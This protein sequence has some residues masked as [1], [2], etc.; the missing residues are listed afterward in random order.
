M[1]KAPKLKVFRTPI[2]FHD[3]YVAAPSQKAAL[4]AWGS[5]HDL[6]ARGVAE[7]VEDPEL[8]REPLEHPGTVIRR[9]R[10]TTAE[11][12]A[13]LPED[14]PR[15]R[16]SPPEADAPARPARGPKAAPKPKPKPKPDRA[17][18]REAEEALAEAEARHADA[19]AELARREAALARER[20]ALEK[21]QSAEQARLAR[22]LDEAR[23]RYDRAIREWRG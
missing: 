13:A 21:Q 7:R 3:A 11:Q 22:H 9:L 5:D 12:I 20:R 1:A 6:F 15:A 4:E 19:Q 14:K 10:G 23:D 2:G 16:R 8:T 18:V 17:P